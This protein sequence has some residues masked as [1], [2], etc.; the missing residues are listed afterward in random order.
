[1]HTFFFVV[2][3]FLHLQSLFI[4]S[5]S[6]NNKRDLS[7]VKLDQREAKKFLNRR[8]RGW[9]LFEE[10]EEGVEWLEEN[11]REWNEWLME[12]LFPGS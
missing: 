9:N 12:G 4:L 11:N 2:I 5:G 10:I 8:K 1:M 7:D 3:F 6:L